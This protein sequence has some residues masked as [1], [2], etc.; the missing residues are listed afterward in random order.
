LELAQKDPKSAIVDLRS[1]LRDQPNSIGV[2]RA[3]ARAHL[4]NGEPALAEETMRRALD[5]N[6][7]DPS[8]REDLAELLVN[9][10]KPCKPSPSSRSC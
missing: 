6:P 1:V 4:A 10:G 8:V 5:A 2:M 3:L 7:K 9:L